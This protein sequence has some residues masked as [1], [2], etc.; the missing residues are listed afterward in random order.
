MN[1][2]RRDRIKEYV[3]S[4]SYATI[5]E[6]RELAPDVSLMTIHRDLDTL[7]SQGVIIKHRGGVESVRR[8]DDVEFNIRKKENNS[9]KLKIAKKALS[10]LQP[11][12][13]IF[14]DAGTSNL[15]FAQ[16]MSDINVNVVTTSP[17][18]ALELSHLHN[19]TVT[20]C[21]G[22]LN[23]KNLAVSGHKT[24]EMLE[25][26]NI[27]TAFIGVSG[28]SLDVGFT[29][30]TEEDMLI[31]KKVIQKARISVVMCSKEKL[32]RLMP[33]TFSLLSDVDYIVCDEPLPEEYMIA[34]KKAGVKVL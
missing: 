10:L 17:S 30:G 19:P 2:I 20:M 18:I 4:K 7:E 8:R 22:T 23:R 28:C 29:C 15:F 34:A 27:D 9:G 32:S 1:R 13:S 33:Y 16:H 26:I 3:E 31:K 25:T 14:L 24:M 5:R 6:L 12:S 11:H 21:C